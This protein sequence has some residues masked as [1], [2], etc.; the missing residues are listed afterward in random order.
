MTLSAARKG[1]KARARPP[2]P[3]LPATPGEGDRAFIVSLY[4]ALMAGLSVMCSRLVGVRTVLWVVG[5]FYALCTLGVLAWW[6]QDARRT[7]EK[8]EE[9]ARRA[10][11]C[12]A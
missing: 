6:W 8:A 3:E 9:G 2:L 11:G 12:G 5:S 10:D 4:F 7:G 1:T